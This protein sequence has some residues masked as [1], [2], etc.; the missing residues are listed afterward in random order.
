MSGSSLYASHFLLQVS[1]GIIGGGGGMM[2]GGGGMMIGG[3]GKIDGAGLRI[4][5]EISPRLEGAK[6]LGGMS[7]GLDDG[8]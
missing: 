6:T 5:G 8:A 3:G 2:I 1:G 4:S 7:S